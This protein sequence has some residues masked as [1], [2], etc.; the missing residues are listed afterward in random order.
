MNSSDD[1]HVVDRADLFKVRLTDLHFGLLS[2]LTQ[3]PP[4][5]FTLNERGNSLVF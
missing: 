2:L 4:T 1:H 3:T 5:M